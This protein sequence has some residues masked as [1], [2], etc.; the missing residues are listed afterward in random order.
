MAE[1][2]RKGADVDIVSSKGVTALFSAA[3]AGYTR[4]VEVLLEA[5]ASVTPTDD[6]GINPLMIAAMRLEIMLSKLYVTEITVCRL[7]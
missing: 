5:G 6:S 4:T 3:Q 2:I 1:L 7:L